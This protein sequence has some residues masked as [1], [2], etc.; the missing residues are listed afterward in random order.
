MT[1]NKR[2]GGGADVGG[3]DFGG[4]V[5][6]GGVGYSGGA[7]RPVVSLKSNAISGGDGTVGNPF[8]VNE[9]P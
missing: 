4:C 2:A 3:V 1:P 5:D 8:Y 6:F 9:E 7:V